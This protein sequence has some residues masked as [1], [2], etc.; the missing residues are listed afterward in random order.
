MSGPK[1]SYPFFDYATANW[2][3]HAR[4]VETAAYNSSKIHASL[5]KL[6]SASHL[7]QAWFDMNWPDDAAEG[8]TPLYIST[9]T[10]LTQYVHLLLERSNFCLNGLYSNGL[11]LLY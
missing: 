8:V 6:F 3:I 11:V 2:H 7:T 10:G 1:L 5:D 9:R 4:Q